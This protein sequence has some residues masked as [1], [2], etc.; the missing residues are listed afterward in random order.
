LE[1]DLLLE[2][3]DAEG[4]A[5]VTNQQVE[6]VGDTPARQDI[7]DLVL[8]LQANGV[9]GLYHQPSLPQVYEA[10]IAYAE[11]GSGLLALPVEMNR[12]DFVLAFRP[13]AVRSIDWGGNPNEALQFED[14]NRKY[15]P[16]ASFRIWQ[17]TVHQTAL[18]WPKET[19][20][21]AETVRNFL[22]ESRLKRKF[23]G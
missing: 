3:L 19:L 9:E 1:K 4:V 21:V 2:L 12:G 14:N 18:P 16:R 8:W 10:A 5:V 13:E 17:Q 20:E 22:I 23:I 7:E 11:N 6:T 15:H